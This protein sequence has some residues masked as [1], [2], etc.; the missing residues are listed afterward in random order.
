MG[1]VIGKDGSGINTLV[2]MMETAWKSPLLLSPAVK[3]DLKKYLP[4]GQEDVALE[5]M[6]SGGNVN[7][8]N[9]LK[10]FFYCLGRSAFESK[11][12]SFRS[13]GYALR[14]ANHL[15]ALRE[16][17]TMLLS[18]AERYR[19]KVIPK[20]DSRFASPSGSTSPQNVQTSVPTL[21]KTRSVS[22]Q[23][24]LSQCPQQQPQ[25][26]Q[27]QQQP[28]RQIQITQEDEM[29]KIMPIEPQLQLQSSF[30]ASSVQT[31][32]MGHKRGTQAYENNGKAPFL[33]FTFLKNIFIEFNFQPVTFDCIMERVS[34]NPVLMGDI[35]AEILSAE[36]YIRLALWYL[37]NPPP[38]FIQH[39][40]TPSQF[41]TQTADIHGNVQVQGSLRT[42]VQL[43][44]QP[45][46]QLQ[47]QLQPQQQL[48]PASP[49]N[50]PSIL[51]FVPP[52]SW[53]W[54]NMRQLEEDPSFLEKK[55]H[56]MEQ[57]F[58]FAITRRF[59]DK[60]K[61]EIS[62][63]LIRQN[64]GALTLQPTPAAPLELFHKQEM[65]RYAN[66][67]VPYMYTGFCGIGA[68]VPPIRVNSLA[69]QAK[70]R[71]HHLLSS[72]RPWCVSILSLVRDSVARLPG[73]VGTRADV[74]K[75]F[76]ESQYVVA[77]NVDTTQISGIVNGAL[78][79]LQAEPSSS[80]KFD[81][82]NKLW[83]YLHRHYTVNDF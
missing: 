14:Y 37:T 59:F 20:N 74:T 62:Y 13:Q 63:A 5:E 79:R 23:I 40:P 64:K 8:G 31:Y 4:K 48:Q 52:N 27:Q 54:A 55:I 49:Q 68:V 18:E 71:A 9:P 33:L 1:K 53:R 19:K 82:D 69:S 76:C 61:A 80:V 50:G 81:S 45:Q 21:I 32:V 78:D 56:E 24:I 22:P 30:K 29:A 67:D 28:V 7:F 3:E 10:D 72:S 15:E 51:E 36:E 70:P 77:T 6:F 43:Q 38:F 66:P 11:F 46:P 2:K 83:T 26:Q 75:L 39:F 65:E 44:P 73:G 16:Y 17:Y 35:P 58:T 60:E 25:T 12:Q 42:Q 41:N 34:K 57:L 47:P